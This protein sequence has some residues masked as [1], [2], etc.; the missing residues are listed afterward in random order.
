MLCYGNKKLRKILYLFFRFLYNI[1]MNKY[2]KL[3]VLKKAHSIC[4]VGHISPDIDDVASMIALKHF[5]KEKFK[6]FKVDI[7]TEYNKLSPAVTDII[8]GEQINPNISKYDCCIM[9]DSPNCERLGKYKALFLSAP[10]KIVIDHHATNDFSGN[11]NI[12]ELV[13]S[14]C[15]IVYNIM[16]NFHYSPNKEIL[17]KIYAGIITDTNGFGVGKITSNTFKIAA[18]CADTLDI[19]KIYRNNLINK[20]LLDMQLLAVAINN[21]EQ[22]AEGKIIFTSISQQELNKFNATHDDLYAVPNTLNNIYTA[23][24][25]CIY[26]YKNNTNYVSF[27]AKDGFDISNLAKQNGGGGHAGAAAFLTSASYED[28]KKMLIPELIKIVNQSK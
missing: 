1:N 16:K 27:R 6:V 15:E 13:S 28:V 23:K 22:F 10:L 4:L 5:L 8:G 21:I 17:A 11:I 9:M 2:K 26:S 19:I 20:S 3:K 18:E 25:I 7:F 14:S 12:V 24:I